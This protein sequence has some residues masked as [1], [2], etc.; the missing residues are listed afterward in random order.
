MKAASGGTLDDED[1]VIAALMDL[2]EQLEGQ[3][4]CPIGKGEPTLDHEDKYLVQ[5]A[6]SATLASPST[7]P[8][9]R[10]FST[11]RRGGGGR[12]RFGRGG[13][14]FR[15]A[16]MAILEDEEGQD[17]DLPDDEPFGDQ[18]GEESL[19][20]DE[21]D[22]TSFAPPSAQVFETS[23]SAQTSTAPSSATSTASSSLSSD[24][25]MAE[26]Y[27]QEYKARNRVREIKRMRQYFQKEAAGGPAGGGKDREQVRRWVKE[28]QKTEPCFICRQLGHWSQECP[29]RNK[30]PIHA[31]NVTFQTATEPNWDLLAQ[32]AQPSAQYKERDGSFQGDPSRYFSSLTVNSE[33]M[34]HHD[35]CWSMQELGNKMILDLGCMKTVAGTTWINP[36]VTKWKQCNR[37]FKVVPE[38]ES[39]RFGD[40]HVNK[41]R[42]AVILIVMIA[43]I[44]CAL[45]I[46]VVGGDCPPLLSKP[47]CTALGLVVDTS[48]HVVSSKKFNVKGYGLKQSQGGHY[49]LTIDRFQSELAVPSDF[50]MPE[51]LEVMPLFQSGS[52]GRDRP[53]SEPT[54]LHPAVH[55][56]EAVGRR[57]ISAGEHMGERG[58]GHGISGGRCGRTDTRP[59]TSTQGS[60]G[61]VFEAS[62]QGSG[63]GI[64]SSRDGVDA[65]PARQHAG[66]VRPDATDDGPAAGTASGRQC[67]T[68]VDHSQGGQERHYQGEQDQQACSSDGSG[69]TISVPVSG[70]LHGPDLQ[71]GQEHL[72]TEQDFQMEDAPPDVAGQEGSGNGFQPSLETQSSLD[73]AH[74]GPSFGLAVGTSG[75][76]PTA[77]FQP[78]GVLPGRRRG[79][80]QWTQAELTDPNAA[81]THEQLRREGD[82][83]DVVAG[84]LLPEDRQPSV[85]ALQHD[86]RHLEGDAEVLHGDVRLPETRRRIT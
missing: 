2:A 50:H 64:V 83:L 16:L 14:R 68:G 9:S 38:E 3:P 72:R 30:A 23:T 84:V 46:S 44:P 51:H 34:V 39:F 57:A 24:V 80:E 12:R 67:S 10:T 26:I 78:Q 86:S 66:D 70:L 8:E 25:C 42:Y 77:L 35:V 11:G 41:S 55:V 1:L 45:R 32:F 13:R 60:S 85:P 59:S 7:A 4:G 40:G 63:A 73:V 36:L 47:V 48:S 19:D 15:D 37:Y 62:P 49:L 82:R 74:A 58:D 27:A 28:Q 31:T 71:R 17:D 43:D 54:D 53:T 33:K 75:S 18:M 81:T 76:S 22:P 52:D 29:Y 5:K 79:G 20:E 69:S 21:D 6:N 65:G 61:G 56:A